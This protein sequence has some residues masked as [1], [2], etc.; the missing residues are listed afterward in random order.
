MKR[1]KK[2]AFNENPE[3]KQYME[4]IGF[5]A[6]TINA[7]DVY[8]KQD[9]NLEMSITTGSDKKLLPVDNDQ[10]FNMYMTYTDS[11]N[12]QY[13]S[14]YNFTNLSNF[15]S[16]WGNISKQFKETCESGDDE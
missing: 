16:G 2:L 3:I 9:R 11:N 10:N 1:L 5:V 4:S 7:I 14:E 8:Y 13:N 15:Q 12:N 6:K